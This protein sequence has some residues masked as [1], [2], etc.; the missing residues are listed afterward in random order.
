MDNGLLKVSNL[1]QIKNIRIF[2]LLKNIL[3]FQRKIFFPSIIISVFIGIIG[4]TLQNVGLYYLLISPIIHFLAYELESNSEYYFYFNIG[5]KK[6][7][8][9]ASTFSIGIINFL[10]FFLL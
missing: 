10:A 6:G 3:V 7:T 8:L 2:R 9:W 5:I 1:G 4:S